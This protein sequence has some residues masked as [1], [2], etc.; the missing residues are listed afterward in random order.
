M[1]WRDFN[2]NIPNLLSMLRIFLLPFIVFC[3]IFDGWKGIL[4]SILIFVVASLTDT[5]DGIMARKL[6]QTS[7]FGAF[8][9]PLADKFLVWGIYI[10]ILIKMKSIVFAICVALI[11][12]RDIF[13]TFLRS[14][15]KKKKIKFKT[16]FLA[17][18]KTSIQIIF[19]LFIMAYLAIS[20]F[21]KETYS[22]NGFSSREL[23]D[24]ILPGLGGYI[25]F[26]PLLLMV[27]VTLITVYSGVDYILNIFLN[28]KSEVNR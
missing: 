9:D 6:N 7:E 24:V 12:L 11:M 22:L 16:S 18:T 27:I 1:K 19:A 4:C 5:F 15:S 8:F 21:F 13:I 2:F 14:Y 10:L 26:L 25:S 20:E 28:N 17:K 23:W 3:F